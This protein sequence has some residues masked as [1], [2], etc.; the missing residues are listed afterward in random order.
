VSQE[1][2]D[3]MVRCSSYFVLKHGQTINLPVRNQYQ[4]RLQKFI[5]LKCVLA[6]P[7]SLILIGSR[8]GSGCSAISVAFWTV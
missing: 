5:L 1:E 7:G 6:A 4:E 3:D 2:I 8:I